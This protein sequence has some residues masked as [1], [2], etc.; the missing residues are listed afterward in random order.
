M[1]DPDAIPRRP[2]RRAA[3]PYDELESVLNRNVRGHPRLETYGLTRVGDSRCPRSLL[4]RRSCTGPGCW[5]N[6]RMNDHAA[7]YRTTRGELVVLWQPYQVHPEDLAE[8]ATSARAD[9]LDLH[10]SGQSP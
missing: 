6:T 5:C 10:L 3:D 2:K 8:V 9:G 7:T 4:P 1:T